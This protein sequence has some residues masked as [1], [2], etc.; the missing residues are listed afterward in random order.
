TSIL[1]PKPYAETHL[2]DINDKNNIVQGIALKSDYLT[3]FKDIIAFP[4]TPGDKKLVFIFTYYCGEEWKT[5]SNEFDYHVNTWSEK[6]DKIVNVFYLLGTI[7]TFLAFTP[8]NYL[9]RFF[10]WLYKKTTSTFKL[11][12]TKNHEE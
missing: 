9:S 12:I 4:K 3:S 5:V 2:Y 11:G 6:N 8:N 10:K 1:T 7:L